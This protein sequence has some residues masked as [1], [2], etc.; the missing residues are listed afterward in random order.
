MT[1]ASAAIPVA[2]L[3]NW[4]NVTMAICE[5]VESPVSPL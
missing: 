3:T 1:A 2:A 5:N 4:R